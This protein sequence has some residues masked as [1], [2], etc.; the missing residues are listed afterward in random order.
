MAGPSSTQGIVQK[1]NIFNPETDLVK[2]NSVFCTQTWAAASL[3]R[4]LLLTFPRSA[5]FWMLVPSQPPSQLNHIN[6]HLVGV[7]NQLIVSSSN[8]QPG[9]TW[10]V[11]KFFVEIRC[12]AGLL[13][14][15]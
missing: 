4:L 6:N 15:C 3:M 5:C 1:R 9:M 7:V 13:D 8:Q 12:C 14:V 2:G 11:V 10:N